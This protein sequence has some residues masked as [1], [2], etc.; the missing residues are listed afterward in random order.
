MHHTCKVDGG[1]S[2]FTPED[3][4]EQQWRKSKAMQLVNGEINLQM[5]SFKL[6]LAFF[7]ILG[8]TSNAREHC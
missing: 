3:T 1:F 4:K 5:Q 2:G 8:P 7:V 6:S